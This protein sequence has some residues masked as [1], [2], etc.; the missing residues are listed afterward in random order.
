MPQ[1]QPLALEEALASELDTDSLAEQTDLRQR[2]RAVI[3]AYSRRSV[4]RGEPTKLM[5]DA[6]SLIGETLQVRL[7][8]TV[9]RVDV[10]DQLVVGDSSCTCCPSTVPGSIRVTR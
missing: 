5:L 3:L 8:G 7:Q 9:D 10:A 4:G 6:A 2:Q 1:S